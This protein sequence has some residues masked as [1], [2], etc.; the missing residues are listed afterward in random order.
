[1]AARQGGSERRVPADG[2]GH[3]GKSEG[4]PRGGFESGGDKAGQEI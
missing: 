4:L 2:F 3:E 1:M